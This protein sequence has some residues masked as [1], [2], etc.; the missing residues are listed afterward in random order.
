MPLLIPPVAN[1]CASAPVQ[2]ANMAKM[3][4]WPTHKHNQY[5]M[6]ALKT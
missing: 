1:T 5:S 2:L 3:D 4:T 6:N